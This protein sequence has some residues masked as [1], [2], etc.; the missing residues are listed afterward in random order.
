MATEFF[1]RCS[2]II[3][4]VLGSSVAAHPLSIQGVNTSQYEIGK[5]SIGR[6]KEHREILENRLDVNILH[7][8]FHSIMRFEVLQP[9]AYS[10]IF[11]EGLKKWSMGFEAENIAVTVGDFQSIFGRGL[12]LNLVEFPDLQLQN[13]LEGLKLGLSANRG[14]ISLISGRD[15]RSKERPSVDFIRGVWGTTYPSQWVTVGG[16]YIRAENAKREFQLYG[17]QIDLTYRFLELGM[18]IGRKSVRDKIEKKGWA[19]YLFGS[20]LH[21]K[22]SVQAEY[23]NY[24]FPDDEFS[25][26]YQPPSVL[27]ES[28]IQLV[29]REETLLNPGDDVG[30]NLVLRYSPSLDSFFALGADLSSSHGDKFWWPHYRDNDLSFFYRSNYSV[31]AYYRF[32]GDFSFNGSFSIL[33]EKLEFGSPVNLWACAII[34]SYRIDSIQSVEFRGE[35]KAISFGNNSNYDWLTSLTY[36]STLPNVSANFSIEKSRYVVHEKAEIKVAGE[37]RWGL[38]SFHD[39]TIGYGSFGGGRRCALGTCRLSPPFRGFKGQ[40]TSRFGG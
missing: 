27:A 9:S 32:K 10:Y 24:K 36:N 4:F 14:S 38:G 17:M 21:G 11:D 35:V 16:G 6:E 39:F 5:Q 28:N 31:N 12:I 3:F 19:G 25:S 13:T 20:F 22:W 8:D 29:A 2:Q 40:L 18:D 34:P 33:R 30:A 1:H 15:T 23:K 37:L 7:S 26:Y